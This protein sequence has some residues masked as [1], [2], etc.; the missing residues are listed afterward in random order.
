MASTA[1]AGST[2]PTHELDGGPAASVYPAIRCGECHVKM[3]DEWE[4]SRHAQ[5]NR[6]ALF[7]RMRK[8]ANSPTCNR[9]HSPLEAL[10][11][12]DDLAAREGVSCETCHR[13]HEVRADPAG[14][15]F[16]LRREHDVKFGPL[17]DA[18]A[19]YFHKTE[20][21]PFFE[22]AELCGSCHLWEMPTANGTIPVYTE[23]ADWK[24]SGYKSRPCQQ[25]HMPGDTAK[26][27]ES[28][29]E[30]P[31][32]PNHSFLGRER[33]LAGTGIEISARV[34]G[35][36]ATI[37]VDAT[38]TNK[39]AGHHLPAG[40]SGRQLILRVR[41]IDDDG[42][43]IARKERIFER[44]LVDDRGRPVPF[45]EATRLDTD[46]RIGPKAKREEKLEL[47]VP[48]AAKLLI[49]LYRRAMG[50]EVA[51]RVGGPAPEEVLVLESETALREPAAKGARPGLPRVVRIKP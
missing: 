47:K 21:K 15:G 48:T 29:E 49:A 12:A 41:A 3:Y 36:G 35:T 22:Q 38:L 5:A 42:K 28:E 17:C 16:E 11:G 8:Q 23:Y 9:C 44:R 31:N 7:R 10:V 19:P 32:V 2:A 30:R 14:A 40:M 20:C 24:A 13:M 43:E 37:T 46:T 45:Y 50:P 6:T 1:P 26:V 39:K 18:K 33:S 4:L 34:Q 25:C 51:R 27:A